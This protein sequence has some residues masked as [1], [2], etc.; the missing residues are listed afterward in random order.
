MISTAV[1]LVPD[2]EGWALRFVLRNSSSRELSAEI[3]EPFLQFELEVTARDG[4]RLSLAQPAFDMQGRPRTL[5]L[6][7]GGRVQLET[8]IRLRFDPAVAPS[9]GGDPMVWSIRAPRQP[10]R[11]RATF[12]LSGHGAQVASG[13]LE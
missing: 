8:P 5:R 13:Q 7:A 10:V 6:P 2:G 12:E 11:L 4:A 3:I 9:G 1:D